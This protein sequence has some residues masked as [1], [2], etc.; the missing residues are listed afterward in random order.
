MILSTRSDRHR[1]QAVVALLQRQAQPR[2]CKRCIKRNQQSVHLLNVQTEAQPEDYTEHKGIK[3]V[4]L[5]KTD[6]HLLLLHGQVEGNFRRLESH[7]FNKVNVGITS[8]INKYE[9][10]QQ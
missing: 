9:L 2:A 4:E 7:G 3:E 5:H 10:I 6:K 1:H 8:N